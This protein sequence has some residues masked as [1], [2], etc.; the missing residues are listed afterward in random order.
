MVE[1]GIQRNYPKLLEVAGFFAS[2]R[3]TKKC[4]PLNV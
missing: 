1:I 3:M 2:L 4:A